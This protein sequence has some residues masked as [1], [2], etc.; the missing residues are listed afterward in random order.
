[1]A[2]SVPK[3]RS[4]PAARRQA[5]TRT[6]VSGRR[7]STDTGR[8]RSPDAPGI[9]VALNAEHRHIATL[10][11]ALSRQSD[12]LLPGR[13][14]DLV[15]VRDIVRY[16]NDFPDQ[17][18]HPREDLLFEL[19][20]QRDPASRD[21]IARLEEG[22]REIYRRSRELLDLLGSDEAPPGEEA[23]RHLKYLCDRYVG[24]YRDHINLEEGVVFPCA[25]RKL[26]RSDWSS[27]NDR[28]RQVDDPL[29]GAR[30]RKE[31]RRLSRHLAT[32]VERIGE[33]IAIAE[34]FGLEALVEGV[35]AGLSAVAEIRGIAR[36]RARAVVGDCKDAVGQS[37]PM[38]QL[39]FVLAGSLRGHA[40]GGAREVSEVLTRARG[41][42]G[43]AVSVRLRHLRRLMA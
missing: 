4:T 32:R 12:A 33:E 14:P 10:L 17:Y 27:V 6:R 42:F 26:R 8:E 25:T 35:V 1:M 19:L 36:A 3:T 39:P 9:M 28:S 30:V 21:A 16:L 38:V 22:H 11:D 43:E 23:R 34:V 37:V 13:T 29:F 18:H 24:F 20:G 40:D 41:E 7:V 31:Y 2:S 15:M 5:G